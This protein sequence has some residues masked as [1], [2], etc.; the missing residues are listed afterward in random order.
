MGKENQVCMMQ[1]TASQCARARELHACASVTGPMQHLLTLKPH[2]PAK[3]HLSVTSPITE[4]N[5][6]YA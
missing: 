2:T 6:T 1:T 5:M 4:T 3:A